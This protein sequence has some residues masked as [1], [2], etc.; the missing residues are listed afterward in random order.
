MNNATLIRLPNPPQ[1][2]P[3]GLREWFRALIR[4]LEQTLRQLATPITKNGYGITGTLVP[5]RTI[6]VSAPTA[7]NA[8]AVL[9]TLLD[10][11]KQRGYLENI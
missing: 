2:A 4:S 8:A 6:N 7:A 10:D 3:E 11:L 9:A 5:T 1:D